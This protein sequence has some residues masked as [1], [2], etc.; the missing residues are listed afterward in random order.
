MQTSGLFTTHGFTIPVKG[1][2][3]VRIIFVGD[4]HRDAPSHAHEKW[5]A[6]LKYFRGLKDAYFF[7]M[8]DY[9]D[10]TSTSERECLGHISPKMHETF[11]NDIQ[12]LQ[13]AKVEMLAKELAFMKGRVIGALNGNHYFEFQSGINSDQKLCELLGAKYLGVCSFVRL[14]FD[15]CGRKTTRD[16]F[17]HHGQGAARLIGGSLNRVAQMFE[18]VE[19]DIVAMGH[20]H[21]RA[22]VPGTPRLFLSNGGGG[23][24][25]LRSR[26]TTVIRSGSYLKSY[27]PGKAN[28]N[29]DSQRPTCDLGHVELQVTLHKGENESTLEIKALC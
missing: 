27:E 8:G 10:S 21:K 19:C 17:A 2:K 24:L 13:L 20:D 1:G 26:S 7:L 22:A 29:V 6:D 25:K 4:V 28:Y 5:Q 14:T 18:G 23:E 3:P 9:L 11:R 12:E 15:H 16:I